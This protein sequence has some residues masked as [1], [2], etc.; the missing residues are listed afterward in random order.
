MTTG[1]PPHMTKCRLGVK[2]PPTHLHGERLPYDCAMKQEI[3]G[4]NVKAGRLVGAKPWTRKNAPS[5]KVSKEHNSQ[6]WKTLGEHR[7]VGGGEFGGIKKENSDSDFRMGRKGRLEVERNI[8]VFICLQMTSSYHTYVLSTSLSKP[9][10]CRGLH[11]YSLTTKSW[12][13]CQL[14]GWNKGPFSFVLSMARP[15]L[16]SFGSSH[17]KEHQHITT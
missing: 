9:T 3:A 15:L 4:R 14:Q 11:G 8:E 7:G 2:P 1:H 16:C 6:S 17:V 5:G 12:K 10:P 13:L